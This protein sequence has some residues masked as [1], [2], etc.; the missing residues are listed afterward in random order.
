TFAL[1]VV[2]VASFLAWAWFYGNRRVPSAP[3]AVSGLPVTQPGKPKLPAPRLLNS[4]PLLEPDPV[5]TQTNFITRLINGEHPAKPRLE[6]LETYLAANHRDAPSL[7]AAFHSTGEK[8][9]LEEA[10]TKYPND[11]QV[12][13]VAWRDSQG[14]P[15]Q[16]RRW[17]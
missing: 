16:R 8:D 17:L 3:P 11:P 13:Y 1:A 4:T 14:S 9:L 15:E 5:L 10:K 2:L 7:L 12:A 6:Q